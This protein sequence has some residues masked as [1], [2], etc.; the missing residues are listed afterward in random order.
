MALVDAPD[1]PVCEIRIKVH[2]VIKSQVYANSSKKLLSETKNALKAPRSVLKSEGGGGQSALPPPAKGF[3]LVC[4]GHILLLNADRIALPGQVGPH[5]PQ[6]ALGSPEAWPHPHPAPPLLQAG[7]CRPPLGSPKPGGLASRGFGARWLGA[8][9]RAP[10]APKRPR[11]LPE[12][13]GAAGREERQ[14]PGYRTPRAMEVLPAGGGRMGRREPGAGPEEAVPGVPG[15]PC[16]RGARSAERP[17]GSR[18]SWG[19]EEDPESGESPDGRTSRTA[20]LVSGLL[21]ELYSCAEE[22]A[23]GA[24]RGPGGRQRRRD[25]LDSSTEASGSDVFLG[26]RGSAGDSRVL[27]ELQERPSQRHQRQYLRQKDTNELK[28]ILRELKYRIGIQSAKLLRQLKQKDRLLHKVQRNCDIVTA[29]LQA[30]S[31]K[32]REGICVA[33]F[34]GTDIQHFPQRNNS[35]FLK[36]SYKSK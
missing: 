14:E 13:A 32:R 29:C 5:L 22:E 2:S 30:V 34:G 27:Q 11:L 33:E 4:S 9:R 8:R 10:Q 18:D 21:T 28:T 16:L 20:S 1:H 23:V 19:A 25:S 12:L 3:I 15:A 6:V 35:L 36:T 26:G 7:S 17:R 24:G 31:Q